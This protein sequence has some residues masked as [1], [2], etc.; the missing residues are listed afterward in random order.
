[1]W[2]LLT[3][4]SQ[5]LK[6]KMPNVVMLIPNP[7]HKDMV[8]SNNLLLKIFNFLRYVICTVKFYVPIFQNF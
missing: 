3:I 5:Y 7:E 6:D 4:V 1:M 8:N 2:A